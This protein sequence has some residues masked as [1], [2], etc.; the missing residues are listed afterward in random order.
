MKEL[1]M[2]DSV[3]PWWCELGRLV[4]SAIISLDTYIETYLH[5]WL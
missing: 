5:T 2:T 1:L 3:C 4:A